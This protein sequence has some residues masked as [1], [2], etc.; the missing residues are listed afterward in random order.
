MR[1]TST[2][3]LKPKQLPYQLAFVAG[4]GRRDAG[5]NSLHN[6]F[7]QGN[8]NGS[9][10]GRF[11]PVSCAGRQVLIVHTMLSRLRSRSCICKRVWPG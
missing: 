10:V 1:L 7:G 8:A 3:W 9:V 4:P 6:A 2:V 11:R 5:K